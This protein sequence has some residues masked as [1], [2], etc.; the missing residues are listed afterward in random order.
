M[1]L[2]YQRFAREEFNAAGR[3][4]HIEFTADENY[5]FGYDVVDYIAEHSPDKLAL[6]W[7]ADD[8]NEVRRF[9]FA[10]IK[11][12][13]DKTANYFRSLGIKKG[14]AV[15]LIL[16]RHYQFWFCMVALHKLGAIAVPATNQLQKKDLVYRFNKANI[17]AIVV[18]ADGAIAESCELAAAEC[19][20]VAIKLLVNGKRSGWEDFNE[21]VEKQSAEFVRP[22][23]ELAPKRDEPMLMYFTSGT[24]G[25]PKL[26]VHS[27]TYS[28]GHLVTA[29]NWLNVTAGGLHLTI[30]E[31]GWG[32]A[33]WGKLYGQWLCECAVMVYDFDR[34]HAERILPLFARFNITTFC[35]PPTIYRFLIKEDLS[36]YDLSSLKYAAVAGEALNAEVFNKFYEQTGLKIM[37]AFGQTETTLT[38][39]NFVGDIPKPGSMGRPNPQYDVVIL[40]HFDQECSTGEVGEISIR[41]HE[42][43]PYGMF[44]GYYGEDELNSEV[45]RTHIYHTGDTAWMDE[46]GYFWFNGRS[47]DLIKSSGYRISPFEI[48][49]VVMELPYVLECAVTAVA[50]ET[51]GQ[52]VKASIVLIA[53][54]TGSEQLAKEVQDY[55]KRTTAPYK[56]PR[57]VEFVSELP[58]T[59]SGKIRRVDIRNRDNTAK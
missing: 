35:A 20:S 10:D 53:G 13:S 9:S 6:N 52:V 23:G 42:Q 43:R 1:E 21:G 12:Y 29:L 11:K 26:A 34:F 36:Q 44:M 33:V 24:T 4:S 56:Y 8:L 49:S 22:S 2:C 45:E 59:I 18:T 3:L 25:Y 51:R 15:M 14:D 17:K 38:I 19:K 32:K 57:I 28:L 40:D 16:K 5:N 39:G 46:E 50:D 47:D 48:E 7:V 41:I 37:E 27:H 55:V 31:T 54:K 30:S 58:K